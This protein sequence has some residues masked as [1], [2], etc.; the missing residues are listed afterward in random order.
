MISFAK[1]LTAGVLVA[2]LAVTGCL[3]GRGT[4]NP[5]DYYG[6]IQRAI[7]GGRI[8]AMIARN[9]AIAKKDFNTC[10]ASEVLA[11]AL[12]SGRTALKG[13]IS[14]QPVIPGFDLD[15]AECLELRASACGPEE[16]PAAE[17]T[18]SAETEAA[19]STPPETKVETTVMGVDVGVLVDT[20]VGVALTTVTHYA[21]KLKE[22]DCRKGAMAFAVIDFTDSM[23]DI[24]GD[25]ITE[26][27]GKVSVPAAEVDLSACG[28][29]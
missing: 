7:D 29:S 12:K 23:V 24:I 6:L 13:K 27:D 3:P 16:A 14:D 18:E 2:S 26:P 28:A 11:A 4:A 9:E 1:R 25:E 20:I 5:E 22:T 10:V 19:P 8:A 21:T 15:L 17:P